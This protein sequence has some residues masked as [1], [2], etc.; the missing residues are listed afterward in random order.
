MIS[1]I[2]HTFQMTALIAIG[3]EGVGLVEYV[4]LHLEAAP[5]TFELYFFPLSCDYS[6]FFVL[7]PAGHGLNLMEDMSGEES[8][9]QPVSLF[10]ISVVSQWAVCRYVRI[11]VGHE[12]DRQRDLLY[13]RRDR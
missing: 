2:W 5:S 1:T 7:A 11:K 10:V 13:G 8:F 9:G 6:G 3:S 4:L 12:S